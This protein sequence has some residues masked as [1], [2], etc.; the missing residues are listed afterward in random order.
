M[1]LLIVSNPHS[2]NPDN[3]ANIIDKEISQGEYFTSVD[4]PELDREGLQ[5]LK[6]TLQS[7]PNSKVIV[8]K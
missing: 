1:Q 7:R 8:N 5:R 4:S 3:L 6:K 2:K